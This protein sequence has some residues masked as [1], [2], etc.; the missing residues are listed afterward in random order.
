MNK[1]LITGASGLLGRA[2]VLEFSKHSW[3]V[4]GLA[5]SRAKDKLIKVDLNNIE[6]VKKIVQNFKV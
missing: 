3:E 6:E 1:V 4:C 2:L 5:F